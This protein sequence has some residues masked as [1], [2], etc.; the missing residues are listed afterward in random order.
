MSEESNL[1]HQKGG[2]ADL[3]GR[4]L[5]CADGVT[6]FAGWLA[7]VCLTALTLL[8]TTSIVFSAL[9]RVVS[10]LP[11]EIPVAFEYSAYL[12]G[13]AFLLG[14]GLTLRA[15]AH[16]R[17]TTLLAVQNERGR[18]MLEILSAFV[19]LGVTL[20]LA[21]SLAR[22]AVQSWMDGQVSAASYTPLWIPQFGLALGAAVLCIQMLARL[23]RVIVDLNP[24]DRELNASGTAE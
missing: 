2:S 23:L 8:I 7:V 21:W 20:L 24:E 12:M 5:L 17:M 9:S 6:V 3:L 15:G 19:G 1:V 13:S 11:G 14:S 16:I 22:F 4:F 10:F 18:R